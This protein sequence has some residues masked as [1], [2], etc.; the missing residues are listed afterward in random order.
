LA[1]M[2]RSLANT[3]GKVLDVMSLY[4]NVHDLSSKVAVHTDYG[5][6]MSVEELQALSAARQLGDLSYEDFMH[7]LKR[8]GVLRAGFDAVANWERAEAE[9]D[10]TVSI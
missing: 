7:E 4:I 8:R 1:S 9:A 5:I 2:A 6:T 10:G 3:L